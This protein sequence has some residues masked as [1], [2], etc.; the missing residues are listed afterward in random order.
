MKIHS[1][2]YFNTFL[3]VSDGT[4]ASC[5]TKPPSKAVK[6]AAEKQYEMIAEHPYA[7]TSDDV[8]FQIYAEK[9]NIGKGEW[10][11]ARQKFFSKGQPCLR[12][13]PLV[14]SYGFGIHYDSDGKIALYGM[15]DGKYQKFVSDLKIKKIKGMK[16]AR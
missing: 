10:D 14:K 8:I 13:S 15:E 9:N 1:T 12:T 6:T 5:G 3:L 16:L 11:T 7:Y 2:N 4:K